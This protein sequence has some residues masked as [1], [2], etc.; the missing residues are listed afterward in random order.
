MKDFSAF[1]EPLLIRM[2]GSSV[3]TNTDRTILNL[4]ERDKTPTAK[5]KI[6]DVPTVD[7][8]PLGGGQMKFRI[9]T[10][11]D[12]TRASMHEAADFIEVKYLIQGKEVTPPPTPDPGD[13]GLPTVDK[14]TDYTI[15]KK[16]LFVIELGTGYSGKILI[17]FVRYANASNPANSGP[18]T[19]PKVAVIL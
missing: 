2:S 19:L 10:A 3:L 4:P 7:I 17:A 1:A 12:A 9:R 6:E 11:E 5:G 14:A 15:S 18:W 16:S 8:T 13:G